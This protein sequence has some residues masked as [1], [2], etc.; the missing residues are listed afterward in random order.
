MT[1]PNVAEMPQ[2]YWAWADSG[3]LIPLGV[4]DD[5]DEAF[6]K[7]E[8]KGPNSHWVFSRQG[9]EEFKSEVLRELPC[10]AL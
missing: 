6:E 4:C 10:A 3:G 9:L 8:T 1:T 2:D 7:A 5:F